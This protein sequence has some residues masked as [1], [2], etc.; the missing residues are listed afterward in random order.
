MVDADN[1]F[2]PTIDPEADV[3]LGALAPTT[4]NKR[5]ANY[6]TTKELKQK[7]KDDANFKDCVIVSARA[8]RDDGD[9][10]RAKRHGDIGILAGAGD[11]TSSM[12]TL[13]ISSSSSTWIARA[14]PSSTCAAADFVEC[15]DGVLVSD[16]VT[17][18]YAEC[19]GDCCKGFDDNGDPVDACIG[20]T[21]KVCKD[22]SCNGYKA[23]VDATIP[24]VVNSCKDREACYYAH[25]GSDGGSIKSMVDSCNG[26]YACNRVAMFDGTIG[27]IIGSCN[28]DHACASA[29]FFVGT[30]GNIIGSCNDRYACNDAAFLY[31]SIGDITE[32][33]IGSFACY[34]L[35]QNYG[36]VGNVVKSC[37]GKSAC[38]DAAQYNGL[39]GSISGSCTADYSC[40]YLGETVGTVGV[41]SGSCTAEFS[42]LSLATGGGKLGDVKDSCSAFGACEKAGINRGS[43]G[44]ITTSCNAVESCVWAG[45][46][47]NGGA[48]T[49]NLNNC[50]NTASVCK[51]AN[52]ATLPT[53]CNSKVR[54]CD[55]FAP[56][57]IQLSIPFY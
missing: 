11:A 54:K 48:I 12:T 36:K 8:G 41:L 4:D 53:Q 10:K 43:L 47:P 45:S 51:L 39:I 9:D 25:A 55:V 52:Q 18:C 26:K 37:L 24:S 31:G 28:E 14:A 7:C 15:K 19:D 29:A 21:G 56:K 23:C 42:C 17:T 5:G 35:G 16:G 6:L 40:H 50:C 20:F 22:G 49:S 30:I 34:Q 38:K 44:S 46:E 32:S 2:N 27:N 1:V 57:L 13:T 33:C 3:I